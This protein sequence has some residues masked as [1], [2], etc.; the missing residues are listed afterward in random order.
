MLTPAGPHDQNLHLAR[1]NPSWRHSHSM[2]AGGFDVMSYTT[3]FTPG[4]SLT[5]RVDIRCSVSY[6]NRAQSAVMPSSLV[7]A[8]IATILSYV[9]PSPITPTLCTGVSTAKYCH[10]SGAA[11]GKI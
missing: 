4:T 9:R 7:T 1:V 5:I 2:V 3:R 6:G 10:G 11:D 8:R